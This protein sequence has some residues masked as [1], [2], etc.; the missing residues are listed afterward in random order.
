MNS[1]YL[2]RE[3]SISDTKRINNSSKFDRSPF[4][5]RF[6]KKIDSYK[7]VKHKVVA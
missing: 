2:K 5:K 4:R 1:I 6:V 7:G 3:L